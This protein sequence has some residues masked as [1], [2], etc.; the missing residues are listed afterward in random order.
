MKFDRLNKSEIVFKIL[1][2]TFVIAFSLAALYP[3]VYAFS[4]SVSGK[5]AY[6]SGQVVLLPRT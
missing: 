2:Y 6:E 5:L 3:V 4:V 1:S